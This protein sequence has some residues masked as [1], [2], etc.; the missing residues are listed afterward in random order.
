MFLRAVDKYSGMEEIKIMQGEK[1]L[2][3]RESCIAGS[4]FVNAS[5]EK[6]YFENV[7]LAG[8]KMTNA[9]L[10]NLEIEGAQLGGAFIHNIGMPPKD[11]PKYDPSA[12]QRPVNFQHC[13]LHHSNFTQC[14]LSG[15]SINE[16]EINGMTINGIDIEAL[17]KVYNE[18]NKL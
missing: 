11:H 6:S 9:D 4:Q 18:Q 14:N 17:L 3:V 12:E 8:S 16:C 13:D 2:D 1:L 15:V 10:S 5:L 7:N